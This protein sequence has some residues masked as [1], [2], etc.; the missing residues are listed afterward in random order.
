M[1]VQGRIKVIGLTEQVGDN[2]SK[3]LLVV[4]T[5][6]TYPQQLPIEFVKDKT[7]ILDK[8]AVGDSVTVDVNLRGSEYKGKYYANIQGWKI[9]KTGNQ[10]PVDN[11][12]GDDSDLPF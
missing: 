12:S 6:E 5:E 2:F 4:E 3:R 8:Y 1:Q 10:P 11:G 7:A 9:E